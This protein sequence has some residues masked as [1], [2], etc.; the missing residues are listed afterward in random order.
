MAR[1]TVTAGR[2]YP[3]GASPDE[4]G[5]NIAVY[6]PDARGLSVCLPSG[7]GKA[8]EHRLA[9][10][11]DG[12]WH[13]HLSR[14]RPGDRYG[15]RARGE[16]SPAHVLFVDHA[17]VLLD[18]YA[19]A[20][21]GDV[22]WNEDLVTPR[23]DT[24]GLVPWA[25]VVERTPMPEHSRPVRPWADSV[26]YEVHV[27][28][29]SM[30]NPAVPQEVRGTYA[31]LAHPA[32]IAHLRALGVN[33][34]ELLPVQQFAT[35]PHLA[36][37]GVH[38]YWGY[39][40][41][42]WSAPHAAYSASGTRGQQ[43]TEFK[44]MVR[45]LHEAGIAVILDVVY[46]HSADGDHLGPT[47]S[48]RGL[49][50][51][52]YYRHHDGG[53]YENVT[54]CGNTLDL[55][56]PRVLQLVLDSLRCWVAEF[57]VDGFRFDL[58]TALARADHGY[59]RRS[60]FLSA[61]AQDPVLQGV[62]LIAEPWDIGPGGYQLGAFPAPW[63]E[64]NGRY[65]DGI[66]ESWRGLGHRSELALRLAGSS[67]IFAPGRRGPAASVNFVTAHDG[68]PLAD[69]V[70]YNEKHNDGN[71]EGGRDGEDHNRSWNGGSEGPTGNPDILR[72]RRSRRRSIL[73][74]LLLSV[75]VP[76]LRGGDE[77]GA[78]QR[79][80]NNAYCQDNA[81]SWLDWSPDTASDPA[82]HDPV[83]P[84]L[85]ARLIGLRAEHPELRRT[86]F[87]TGDGAS[88]SR[89][90]VTWYGPTGAE[91]T[92]ADWNGPEPVLGMLL[93]GSAPLLAWFNPSDTVRDIVLPVE[94]DW[95]RYEI[96]I[97]TA[98]EDPLAQGRIPADGEL[99][100]APWTVLVLRE[101]DRKGDRRS[102]GAAPVET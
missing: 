101:R 5:T 32:S 36:R 43:V 48:L 56:E 76:M 41:Y 23:A 81:V 54:G 93:A 15:L 96:V 71:G 20:F 30:L 89:K 2:P 28:G 60:A 45:A 29:F 8:T 63:A 35:E 84:A 99:T 47:L 72:H 42:G 37:R 100:C 79:G 26:L 86:A 90:D 66:R 88:A 13:G 92:D 67:D 58:A 70:S 51:R 87:F 98:A 53:A 16:L 80:N 59:D 85:V 39:N 40:T 74:T 11:T 21:D 1:I 27:K 33:A 62:A 75:G 12:V 95:D 102:G 9:H 94:C 91:L 49:G 6:A 38:N 17:K 24:E 31:G 57:G 46:N 97:D 61:I 83:L 65:R 52:T 78:T 44:D 55:R 4:R 10:C 18:P 14:L 25:V 50:D 69:L 34:V 3:L 19:R 7:E 82:G 64:W 77:R 68:F 22:T 73:A